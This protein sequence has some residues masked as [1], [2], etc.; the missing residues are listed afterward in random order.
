[1]PSPESLMPP[2]GELSILKPG[3]SFTFTVPTLS[4][5][6]NRMAYAILFVTIPEDK[7][8]AVEFDKAIASSI[9]LNVRTGASGPKDSCTTISAVRGTS[10][11][12]VGSIKAPWRLPPNNILAPCSTAFFTTF[13][14]YMAEAS[15]MTVPTRVSGSEGS[16]Q[17]YSFDLATNFTRKASFIFT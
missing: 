13:S 1:M 15:S 10:T 7:P 2:N 5:L 12:T 11:I 8:N 4:S 17:V 14:R 16:P 3:I 9:S 6:I